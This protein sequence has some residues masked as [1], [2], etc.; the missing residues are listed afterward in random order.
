MGADDLVI[1]GGHYGFPRPDDEEV[2][3]VP[4]ALEPAPEQS[5][6]AL[7]CFKLPAAAGADVF[8]RDGFPV[9]RLMAF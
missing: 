9:R 3:G 8:E 5:Q 7:D 2:L 4:V 1:V 6:V